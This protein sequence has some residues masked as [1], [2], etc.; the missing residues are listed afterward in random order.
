MEYIKLKDICDLKNGFAF[1]SSDYIEKSNVLNC[2]MSNIRPNATFDAE[3]NPKYLPEEFC[4]K[5]EEYLLNDGDLIIAMT[6]LA[7]DPKLLGVPTIVDTKGYKMLL[8]QRVGKLTLIDKSR[9][10][11][12]YLKYALS[13][14]QHKNYFKKFAGGGLQINIGKQ[15][16]LNLEIPYCEVKTQKK[17]VEVLDKAQELI[18]KRKEQIEELDELVKSRFIEMFGDP[19]RNPKGW[20]IEKL[21]NISSVGSSKRVFVDELVDEGIPFY[22]GTEIGALSTG[23]NIQPTLFITK[24]HYNSLKESTGVPVVGDL[25]M[26]SI[27]P[28]GRIWIVKD[29]QPFYFKD[30]RVLWIHLEEKNI[31]SIYLKHM[32]RE[33]FIRDYNKIASGTTFAELKIFAL[34]GLDILIPP[35]ELQNQF[36]DFVN[37][38]DKL[39]SK[40]ETSLKE[41]ED[42]FNSLM[43]KA[44]KGELF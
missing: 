20:K 17:I 9:V 25:L 2:R 4:E 38:V 39:K 34:K 7:N 36:A 8:N 31:N 40:M 29:N 18:D 32:L 42:N 1:K 6:D 41:L 5:Y 37:Q 14:P 10:I 19:V 21:E 27:C 43:Q 22:R 3:Y 16:I 12:P 26:P 23:E 30:G 28:D 15:E 44:F 33:K 11:E 24:E 35:I 13:L